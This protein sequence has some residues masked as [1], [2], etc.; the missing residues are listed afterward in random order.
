MGSSRVLVQLN[1][2]KGIRMLEH[3]IFGANISPS[4]DEI[5]Y[6]LIRMWD[7]YNPIS[8]NLAPF[9]LFQKKI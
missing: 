8:T 9:V 3:T 2:G 5:R 1:F 7:P 4:D 6:L